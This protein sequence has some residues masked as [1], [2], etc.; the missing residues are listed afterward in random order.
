MVFQLLLFYRKKQ[1]NAIKKRD[2]DPQKIQSLKQRQPEK[3]QK[4]QPQSR[5]FH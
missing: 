1:T 2:T 4:T 3:T 5:N